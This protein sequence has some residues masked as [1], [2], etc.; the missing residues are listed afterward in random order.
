[1]VAFV[2]DDLDIK[3]PLSPRQQDD[4]ELLIELI[5][6]GSPIPERFYRPSI[7]R[8]GDDLLVK[9][10]VMHLHLDGP[11]DTLVYLIH[12]TRKPCSSLR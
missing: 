3:I 4:L 10:R 12:S 1:M 2:G 11:S 8:R 9:G 5:E 6:A 7:N